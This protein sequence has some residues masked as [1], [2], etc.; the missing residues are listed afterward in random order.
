MK[1]TLADMECRLNEKAQLRSRIHAALQNRPED[2]YFSKLD[3]S[4]KKNTAFVRKLKNFTEAQK[5]SL[6]KDMNSLNLTKYISEVATG[7]VEAKLKMTDI[8]SII[9]VCA[10]LHEKYAEFSTQLLEAWQKVLFLKK[11]E[12]VLQHSI[13]ESLN[14]I[15][16]LVFKVANPSKTRVDVR[17]YSDLI[18][19]GVLTPKE[20]LPLLGSF[21]MNL[22][23]SD[24]E[25]HNNATIILAFCKF[26]GEDYAGLVSQKLQ[27]NA[28]RF[29][30]TIPV[31]VWLPSDKRQNV[32]NLLR[33]YYS[34]LCKHLIQ[35][36]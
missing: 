13:L 34:S 24:K 17:F 12:K 28:S 1:E 5:E 32:R 4:I 15:A 23:N 18:S 14:C 30:L 11:D 3:S 7:I 26:C 9:Q 22:I 19:S 20:G 16:V 10:V 29:N 2:S 21:L 33:D 36:S 25:E 27:Q 35:V 8:P 6:M 31:S